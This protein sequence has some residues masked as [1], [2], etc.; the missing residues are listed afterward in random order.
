MIMLHV[1]LFFLISNLLEHVEFYV[2]F[3]S[4]VKSS[5]YFKRECGHTKNKNYVT[6]KEGNS[7][8]MML[9]FDSLYAADKPA[10][11]GF[12]LTANVIHAGNN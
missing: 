10:D 12:S 6:T 2:L 8:L 9:V 5:N 7:N 3:S 4:F 11:K 1:H